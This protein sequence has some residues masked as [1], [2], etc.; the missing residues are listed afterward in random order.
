[1]FGF[2]ITGRFLIRGE[3]QS[4]SSKIGDHHVLTTPPGGAMDSEVGPGPAG[5]RELGPIFPRGRRAVLTFFSNVN[6]VVCFAF[7][8]QNLHS[9][10]PLSCRLVC[11]DL[12]HPS[13]W[14]LGQHI[15]VGRRR[16]TTRSGSSALVMF[17]SRTCMSE[18]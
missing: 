3:R 13:I 17:L 18:V 1:M 5:G 15:P 7:F 10:L 16:R 8:S 4:G 6:T 12:L 11:R 14:S 9:F 2:Q